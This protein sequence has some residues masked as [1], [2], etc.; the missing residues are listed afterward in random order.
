[1]GVLAHS[2]R[3]SSLLSVREEVA[4]SPGATGIHLASP[5]GAP[6]PDMVACAWKARE[7]MVA[8]LLG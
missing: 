8:S 1:M 5:Q 3:A 4:E 7:S 6:S 2:C